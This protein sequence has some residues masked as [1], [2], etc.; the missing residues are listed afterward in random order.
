MIRERQKEL[1]GADNILFLVLVGGCTVVCFII[2][3]LSVHMCFRHYSASMRY[4]KIK[5]RRKKSGYG[6][7]NSR[8]TATLSA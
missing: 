7:I 4:L 6:S 2:F 5:K 3:L 1:G 8:K